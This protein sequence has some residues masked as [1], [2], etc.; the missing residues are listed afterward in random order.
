MSSED[1]EDGK[2]KQRAAEKKATFEEHLRRE[3]QDYTSEAEHQDGWTYWDNFDTPEEFLKDF[4]IYLHA[5]YGD[6]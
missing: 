3:Y 6:D 5:L 1:I 4:A 2:A